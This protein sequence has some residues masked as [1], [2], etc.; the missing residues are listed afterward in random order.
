MG[1]VEVC[2]ETKA[3]VKKII[4]EGSIDLLVYNAGVFIIEELGD[5]TEENLSLTINTNLA[6]LFKFLLNYIF[7]V[8]FIFPMLSCYCFFYCFKLLKFF[9]LTPTL[10]SVTPVL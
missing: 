2:I 6:C 3:A 1:L 7:T 9:A 4:G 5:I 8:V 10:L